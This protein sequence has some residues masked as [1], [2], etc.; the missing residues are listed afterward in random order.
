MPRLALLA[1]GAVIASL[2]LLAP[3]GR[4][5]AQGDS[6]WVITSFDTRIVVAQ[7]GRIDVAED[8]VVD[9]GTLQ[10][11][12][13][14]REIPLEYALEDDPDHN[15]YTPVLRVAVGDGAGPVPF[16]SSY[17]G[18]Y[19]TLKIGDPDVLVTGRQ[20]YRIEYA[21][22]GA[23]NPFPSHDELYWNATGNEW[24]V[25]ILQANATVELPAPAIERIACYQGP[26]GAAD[27]C[28]SSR[29]DRTARFSSELLGPKEGLT[30]V[31]GIQKGAVQVGPPVLVD[32]EDTAAE[33][34]RNFL[35]VDAVATSIAAALLVAVLIGVARVWW[36]V[37]RDRWYGDT[38]YRS[39]APP[40]EPETK[41]LFAHQTVVVEYTPPEIGEPERRL[42]PAEIGVLLDERA[43]TLD[44]SATIVDLAVRKYL[45][46]R[47]VQSGGLLGVFRSQDYEL[48][49]LE[50]T[51][52]EL[53]S[54]ER[55]LYDAL[56]D[57]RQNVKLSDLKNRFHTDLKTVKERL[58]TEASRRSK[59]FAA[60]PERTRTY[61]RLVGAG[62]AAAGG[63]AT[64]LLGQ[65]LG[66]GVIGFPI[67]LGGGALFLLAPAMPR[68]TG[69]GWEI[70]RR[71]LGFRLY[72]VTAETDRQKFAEDE[73]IFH[74][75]LPYAIVFGCVKKWAERFEQLGIEPQAG[76][77]LGT[78]GF[79][80]V[81]FAESVRDFSGSISGVM[82]STPGGSGGSGFG[83]GGFS[84]GGGGGGGGGSW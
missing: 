18:G 58:Y 53:L 81:H 48:E 31:V 19:L 20:R 14:F 26:E 73:N 37:G 47:E 35:G 82:A 41:P 27:P 17:D 21:L 42:R 72:M 84:G 29:Q 1:T 74:E 51:G 36:L 59:F 8:I 46:I 60:D 12:G 16:D 43:D 28:A 23:L 45:V 3:A 15:R 75:Y 34:V 63:G 68:R 50:R 77:Y 32:A 4:A 69:F 5:A 11:H 7:D 71:C 54:Y 40:L 66:A 6:G 38:Y 78:R 55:K 61:Y 39:D 33:K 57:G 76:Y 30:V 80:P 9:F 25:P 65:A 83:G 49:R 22:E 79:A 70:Y 10:R 64:W 13:I 62:V 56:F 2:A 24:P 52:D 44:V 67:V